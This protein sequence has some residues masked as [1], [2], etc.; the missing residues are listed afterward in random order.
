MIG[1]LLKGLLRD[2]SRSL[3][4]IIIVAA[5][6]MLTVFLHAWLRGA[7]A[8]ILRSTAHFN[9]GDVRVM[10]RA[11]AAEASEVPND[12]AL[13]GT[14]TL[15]AGLRRRYP[16]MLWT[17]RIMFGGL[18]DIP[19]AKGETR[20]QAPIAGMGVD[21]LSDSSPEP[22]YL[23]LAA[24][25]VR[26]HLPSRRGE[27]LVSDELAGR[28]GIGPG[29]VATLIG[30]TMYGSMALANFTV[31]GTVRFGV[32]P[33]DRG[34]VIADVADV[35]RALDMENGAGEILGFFPD[36]LYHEAV[37]DSVTALFNANHPS[38]DQFAPVMG[39]LRE[40]S[41]LS[42]YFDTI[43][44]VLN[45]LIAFFVLA[46][47][48]VLWNAGLM[49]SLRRYGEIGVRLAIGEAKGQVYRSMLIES[50]G[51]GLVGSLVGTAVGLAFAYAVQVHGFDISPFVKNSSMMVDNVLRAHV[52][53]GSA[54]IGFVPGLM[55]TLLGTAIAGIGIYRRQTSQL[56]KELEA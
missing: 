38:Q 47:A 15:L 23:N 44:A 31:A 29:Q 13:L 17:P 6:V 41:G 14:D 10:T 28:L 48:I 21:L 45:G 4:P 7:E 37:A 16:E 18:L 56:F 50:L 12:L 54:M 52:T 24:S 40:E 51:I 49:G 2:R 34:A 27:M 42:D 20:A 43:G 35:R 26:G 8:S 19:D 32:A 22:R 33:M 25:I 3:F 5:G 30:S 1:F 53:I 55:A 46:M 9:T 39:T 11:Y 36:D